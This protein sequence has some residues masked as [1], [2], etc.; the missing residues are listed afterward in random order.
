MSDLCQFPGLELPRS[1]P[2]PAPAPAPAKA[3]APAAG[4]ISTLASA[5]FRVPSASSPVPVKKDNLSQFPQSGLPLAQALAPTSSRAPMQAQGSDPSLPV[6]VKKDNLSQFP[7]LGLPLAQALAPTSSRA[8]MQA[9]AFE[10]SSPVPVKKDNLSQFPESGLPLA[11][12]L[13]PTSS[14]APMQAQV[15]EPSSPMHVRTANLSQ[16]PHAEPAQDMAPPS[17]QSPMQ[18][19]VFKP[20]PLVPARMEDLSEFSQPELPLAIPAQALVP[21]STQDSEETQVS[22]APPGV[23]E[24]MMYKNRLQEYTQK[25]MVHFPIYNTINEGS[26]H[27]PKYR[28]TVFVDGKSFTSPDTFPQKKE[29]EQNVAQIALDLLSQKMKDEGCPLIHEDAIFCK[30]ILNEYAAKMN[31]EMPNYT[32]IQPQ[33]AVPVFASSL[34]FNGVTYT[35][36]VGKSKKEAE[37]LAARTAIQS[38]YADSESKMVLLRT[39]K[40]KCKLY[41]AY[42]EP[43]YSCPVGA[44]VG[45]NS[46]ISNTEHKE[47]L[48]SG[49]ADYILGRA[50]PEACSEVPKAHHLFQIPRPVATAVGNPL[51]SFVPSSTEQQPIAATSSGKKRRK[52]KKKANKKPRVDPQLPNAVMMPSDQAP[53]CSVAQ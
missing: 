30:S 5:L 4:A 49:P 3:P 46:E 29:A 23:P 31:L 20:S 16:L 24:H 8:P 47:A 21:T 19:P 36:G 44:N 38:L 14:R 48:A 18:A 40:S 37:Q 10:P 2:A 39:I 22:C 53:P 9:Q 43:K 6:P 50:I 34:V 11:Q 41:A 35:G 7:Q 25:L 33:G 1:A 15:L 26:Q 51:I 52:N 27:A 32:T 13:A 28:S 17:S 45:G 12:A 42:R